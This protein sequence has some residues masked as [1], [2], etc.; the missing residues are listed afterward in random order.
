M[1]RYCISVIDRKLATTLKEVFWL[2]E[3]ELQ[4]QEQ[5][6]QQQMW[7]DSQAE[8]MERLTNAVHT[9]TMVTMLA[10]QERYK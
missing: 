1:L 2:L 8:Q 4:R 7:Y 6:A 3:Q 5:M 9:N 10:N